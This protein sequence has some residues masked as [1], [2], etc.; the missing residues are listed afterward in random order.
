ML[1]TYDDSSG[2][3]L[4][5][6]KNRWNFTYGWKKNTLRPKSGK[7]SVVTVREVAMPLW[8]GLIY[9]LYKIQ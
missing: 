6:S 9:G 3:D 5:I 8:E 2:N 4:S 1:T 7:Y